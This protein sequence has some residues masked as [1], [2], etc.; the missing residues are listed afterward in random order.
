MV[1]I[2]KFL[3]VYMIQCSDDSYYVGVTNDL[4]ERYV[5]HE[6]GTNKRAYTFTRRPFK[7]LYWEVHEAAAVA[8]A[9]EKQLKGW[10]RAKK[11]A[12]VWGEIE[13]LKRLA[14][15]RG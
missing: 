15:K 4:V 3:Y 11:K 1:I 12:L 13:E 14:R 8:I 7:L 5:D 10:T 6:R 2:K 9:R